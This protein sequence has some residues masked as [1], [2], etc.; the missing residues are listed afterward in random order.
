MD[1]IDIGGSA[2]SA[3]NLIVAGEPGKDG[4]PAGWSVFTPNRALAPCFGCEEDSDGSIHLWA[5]GNG[6]RECFGS[7][8]REVHLAAGMTLRLRVLLHAEGLEDLNRH[9]V[10]GVFAGASGG[11]NDGIFHYTVTADGI[12]GE[13]S[14][15]GPEEATDA[16][17]R[18][19]FRFSAA[20]RVRW[21]WV[22][23]E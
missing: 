6:R 8:R 5:Q 13:A 11:F 23:L 4:L 17:I 18:L 20:G 19:Y 15:R 21:S 7:L 12:V 1:S 16:E 10:H 3:V 14:F 22:S 2:R 9:L